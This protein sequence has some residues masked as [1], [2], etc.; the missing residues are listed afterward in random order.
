M[1]GSDEIE[2]EYADEIFVPS[3]MVPLS[4]YNIDIGL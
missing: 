4:D 2:N 3:G 1:Q